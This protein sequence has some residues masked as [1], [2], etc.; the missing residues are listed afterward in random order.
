MATTAERKTTGRHE[1]QQRSFLLELPGLLLAALLVAVVIKTF[2]I[3]PFYIPSRSMVPE[4]LVND[5]VMVSKVNLW[6][7][8]PTP[9]DIV[10]F[11]NPS[12]PLEE[13]SVPERVVR[14]V[15]E[16]LGI[17]TNGTEDLIKRVVAVG[18]Q[19]VEIR[20][21]QVVIDGTPLVEDYL[22]EGVFMSDMAPRL[23]PDGQLWMM[24][25][26][27]NESSDSRVFGPIDGE[28]VIGEAVV[29]IWPLDRVGGL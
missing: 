5:R 20:D 2:L 8:D 25:D 11:R 19:T 7:G 22:P 18:G 26:N 9:G 16:A 17:R 28:T 6:F 23:I 15:V 29:R 13:E 4:L 3:Q 21:N 27:R 1:K 14:A 10:V 12:T 24:G